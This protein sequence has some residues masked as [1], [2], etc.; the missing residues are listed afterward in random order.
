[1]PRRPKRWKENFS[2]IIRNLIS[3]CE[4]RKCGVVSLMERLP[5]NEQA[6][7]IVAGHP[8]LGRA[9]GWLNFGKKRKSP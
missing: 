5:I 6:D 7:K 2:Q 8:V 9:L 1:M 3:F 4:E